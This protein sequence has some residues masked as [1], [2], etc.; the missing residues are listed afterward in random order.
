[1]ST[2]TKKLHIS[3][4]AYDELLNEQ[5]KKEDEI[6]R[7]NDTIKDLNIQ[8]EKTTAMAVWF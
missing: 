1:V 3:N 5:R 4:L 6:S 8:I 2:L 7:L